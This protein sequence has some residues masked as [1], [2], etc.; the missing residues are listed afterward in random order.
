EIC[1]NIADAVIPSET[2]EKPVET[3]VVGIAADYTLKR[4]PSKNFNL[5]NKDA[6]GASSSEILTTAIEAKTDGKVMFFSNLGNCFRMTVGDMPETRYRDNGVTLSQ[7]FGEA[8]KGEIPVS[9]FVLGN[10]E[11]MKGELLIYT[12]QGLIKRSEWKEYQL[13]K[14]VFQGYKG[15][16]GD[17]VFQVEAVKPDSDVFYVTNRGGC[18]RFEM[19]EIPLQGRVAGGVRCIN[20]ADDEYVVFAGQVEKDKGDMLMITNKG[21]L[22]RLPVTEITKHARNCK[23][24]KGIEFGVNGSSIVYANYVNQVHYKVAIFDKAN[25]CVVDTSEVSVENKN[26]KGK[27]PKGKR[28][29]IAV[30]KIIQFKTAA[31]K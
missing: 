29:G 20:L 15:K 27:L 25:V 16:D 6:I 23:G 14:Q 8:Q 24:A 4:I 3:V 30:E 1:K 9:A 10:E 18:T 2:D 17:E 19:N 28:G 21:F 31:D 13:L 11:D 22:K 7:L 12:R 5:S 26:N